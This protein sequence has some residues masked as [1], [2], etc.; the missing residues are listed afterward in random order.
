VIN[1]EQAACLKQI[2]MALCAQVMFILQVWKWPV[3]DNGIIVDSADSTY[4]IKCF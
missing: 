1:L 3:L 2:T 4:S